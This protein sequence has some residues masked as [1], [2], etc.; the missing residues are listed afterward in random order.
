MTSQL[1]KVFE[2]IRK[3][4]Q[5]LASSSAS[6]EKTVSL[7]HKIMRYYSHHIS[8][9]DPVD[10][11]LFLRCNTSLLHGIIE[12]LTQ[13]W[14]ATSCS[15]TSAGAKHEDSQI[16][17]SMFLSVM[18]Y[19]LH[20]VANHGTVRFSMKEEIEHLL[21]TSIKHSLRIVLKD[22]SKAFQHY[23]SHVG[24]A[25]VREGADL[26]HQRDCLPIQA[27]VASHVL[28][29][30]Q[31]S[32]ALFWE[33]VNDSI[34][35]TCTANQS[36]ARLLEQRW[37][38]IL[39]LL[40]FL[41]LNV[42]GKLENPRQSR[43]STENWQ[44][45]KPLIDTVFRFYNASP[46]IQHP[47]FN[48]YCR[49]LYARC[50]NL[51]NE[52]H[53]NSW[54]SI[55]PT[56]FDFFA[57]NQLAHLRNEEYWGNHGSPAFLDRLN[58]SPSLEICRGDR[59][60]HI[61]LKIIGVLLLQIRSSQ[62]SRKAQ[63]LVFRVMPN[64]GRCLHKESNIL[65]ADLDALR[66]HH[67]LLCTLY[68]ASPPQHRPRLKAF[69]DLVD[70]RSS[71][72]Q[73]CHLNILAWSRLVNFQLS[74]HEPLDSLDGFAEWHSN[75]L[76]CTL[77]QHN[78]ARTDGESE[79]RN[80]GLA[81]LDSLSRL[82]ISH[83]LLQLEPKVFHNELQV[84]AVIVD[85]LTALE[86]AVKGAPNNEAAG[87][88]IKQSLIQALRRLELSL[89]GA[90]NVVL[91]ALD[92]I[93]AYTQRSKA[94]SIPKRSQGPNEES[95]DFGDWS[96]FE[97]DETLND[98]ILQMLEG[99]L[100]TLLSNCFGADIV[101]KDELL[102][103]TVA[104]YTSLASVLVHQGHKS[105]DEYLSPFG[106]NSWERLRITPQSQKYHAY[107]LANLLELNGGIFAHFREY[108]VKVWLTTI[109]EREVSLKF[110][111]MLTSSVLN[112]GS[113]DRLLHNPPFCVDRTSVRFSITSSDFLTARLS[114]ITTVLFNMW[115][116]VNEASYDGHDVVTR[117][118]Q[119]YKEWLKAMMA[120]MKANYQELG[121]GPH[122]G[123][124]YVEFVQAIIQALH[125]S[126]STICPVDKFFMD[127][128]EFP[129]PAI[130]PAY[131]VGQLQNYGLRLRDP[132]TPKQL[133]AFLQSLSEQAAK[134]GQ[135]AELAYRLHSAMADEFE[136]RD[137]TNPT[138]RSFLVKAI[139]PAYLMVGFSTP[140]GWVLLLPF[141]KALQMV[142]YALFTDFS[143][144]DHRSVASVA[145]ILSSY[146]QNLWSSWRVMLEDADC[147]AKRHIQHLLREC[148]LTVTALLPVLDYI[149]RL[150]RSIDGPLK[151]IAA[152][153]SFAVWTLRPDVDHGDLVELGHFTGA[154]ATVD[155]SFEAARTFA[156]A[157]LERSLQTS[158]LRENSRAHTAY[159]VKIRECSELEAAVV[160]LG[161]QEEELKQY[162]EAVQGF[163]DCLETLPSFGTNDRR[164]SRSRKGLDLDGLM[165][166]DV[167]I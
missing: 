106:Q 69:R 140:G 63:N 92:I 73:A 20:Q 41:E 147:L 42:Y 80:A 128:R 148:Y 46:T 109:V 124:A 142:F 68:W 26:L 103:K 86:I 66:N 136:G 97:D 137:T 34:P 14:R 28:Y 27:L 50:F 61:L 163:L 71:H 43:I 111:Y 95:Q 57:Q 76:E 17:L 70:M 24:V 150:H 59:C 143:A 165:L 99:S 146:L 45:T 67:D 77:D 85:A 102:T 107:Y 166:H 108:F 118:K 120:A 133:A 40:P 7:V 21:A 119:Q 135:Q 127:P 36:D 75:M 89:R 58:E 141:L 39:S 64:H 54:H 149:N 10:R 65:Q 83:K 117:T 164:M 156:Q 152:L 25:N 153:K 38:C 88:L 126:T 79:A 35:E 100:R 84:E 110:Q 1:E 31:G 162:H 82:E 22:R 55:L 116:G 159:A 134:G 16:L 129:P 167:V 37:H 4:I 56:L 93:L 33:A 131:V 90:N 155:H 12:D 157:E 138:L 30:A 130:D 144:D 151:I 15:S 87:K 44:F 114:L 112:A 132:K 154:D 13:A 78:I 53:W 123:G 96:A 158:W 160:G 98:N 72:R 9:V 29:K 49:K 19:Q 23:L 5:D 8:F 91:K 52:W 104:C 11:V 2:F 113:E 105:W 125:K 6:I 115:E 101:P 60:F 32:L 3:E 18:V 48:A 139:I 62:D 161:S 51:I 94:G 145:S 121:H 81:S 74:I 122:V 47:S